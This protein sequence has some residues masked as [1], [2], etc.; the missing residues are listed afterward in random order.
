MAGPGMRPFKLAALRPRAD[1][2]ADVT[3]SDGFALEPLFVVTSCCRISTCRRSWP[4]RTPVARAESHRAVVIYARITIA[5]PLVT[6]RRF[7]GAFLCRNDARG[8][9]RILVARGRGGWRPR[10]HGHV[11]RIR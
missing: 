3:M 6:W 11:G 2:L 4:C 8:A 5:I 1:H 9:K 10:G 7:G